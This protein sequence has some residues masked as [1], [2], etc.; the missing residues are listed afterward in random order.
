M[1]TNNDFD[2]RRAKAVARAIAYTSTFTAERA[3]N[4]EV[5]DVEG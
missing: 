2:Q 1:S 3:E 4:T 5:W